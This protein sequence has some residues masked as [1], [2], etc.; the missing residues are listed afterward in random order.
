MNNKMDNINMLGSLLCENVSEESLVNARRVYDNVYRCGIAF[1]L[2][3][4]PCMFDEMMDCLLEN[5]ITKDNA[6]ALLNSGASFYWLCNY[7]GEDEGIGMK[8]SCKDYP[9]Y[10]GKY[11]YS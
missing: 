5:G 11:D 9:E 10:H 2:A 1:N 7:K 3:S 4:E 6:L 8:D